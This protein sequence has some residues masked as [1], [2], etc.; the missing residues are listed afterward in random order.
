MTD[1]DY[2]SGEGTLRLRDTGTVIEFWVKAG[3]TNFWW[4][5]LD[6]SFTANGNTYPVS[7]DYSSGAP[8]VKVGS[9]SVSSSQTVYFRLL[10]ATGTSSL[11]GPTTVSRY[12][13]RGTVPDPPSVVSFSGLGSDRVTA[14]FSDPADNG[15]LAIT[16]RQIAY[17]TSNTVSGATFVTSDKST[18]ITGLKPGTTY[19]FWARVYNSKGWSGYPAGRSVTTWRVPDAPSSVTYSNVKQN[20]VTTTFKANGNGGTS[21]LDYQLAYNTS[22][23]TTGATIVTPPNSGVLTVTNLPPGQ[24]LYF[25]AR[26]RNSVG[27]SAWSV[28]T[29]VTLIAGAYV[30]YNGVPTRAVPFVNVN[31]V[32]KVARPW[33][34][35]GD[36]WKESAT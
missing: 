4:N 23:T 2:A 9:A 13:D 15:G 16:N 29:S 17:N 31:G 20:S 11:A 30:V 6:F 26:A 27:Y 35:N 21:I 7:I 18:L 8:W 34:K 32:W 33:S 12:F 28:V 10:T 3:Y 24:K 36:I 1:Y 25:W 5:G 14:S 19:W 22:N